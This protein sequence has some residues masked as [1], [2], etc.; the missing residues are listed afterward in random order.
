MGDQRPIGNTAI[1]I[2]VENMSASL[3]VKFSLNIK[4]LY[5]CNFSS[6]ASPYSREKS[7]S[8]YGESQ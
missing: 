3:V 5:H 4:E 6:P 2:Y 7:S 1:P 8:V